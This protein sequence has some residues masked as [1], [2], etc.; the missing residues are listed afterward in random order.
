VKILKLLFFNTTL[1]NNNNTCDG[2][3][4]DGKTLQTQGAS[5]GPC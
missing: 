5:V 1:R 3:R 2:T 4:N